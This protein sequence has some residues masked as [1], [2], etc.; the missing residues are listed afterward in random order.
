MDIKIYSGCPCL[1]RDSDN[2]FCLNEAELTEVFLVNSK[3]FRS[4]SGEQK[5]CYNAVIEGK[6][7][8]LLCPSTGKHVKIKGRKVKGKVFSEVYNAVKLVF[9]DP[10][11]CTQCLFNILSEGFVP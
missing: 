9:V 2:S 6:D 1:L 8:Y 4:L 10:S 3:E 5:I 7:G 11:L